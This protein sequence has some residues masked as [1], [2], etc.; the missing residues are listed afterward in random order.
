LP[1]S[2]LDSAQRLSAAGLDVM[3]LPLSR[4]RR[5]ADPRLHFQSM[6]GLVRDVRQ[7][8]RAI[9]HRSISLVQVCG[10][11]NIQGAIAARRGGIP[12][13]W[14]L[15]S[16]LVPYPIRVAMMPVVR[17]AADIVMTTGSGAAVLNAFPGLDRMGARWVPF[18]NPVD[19]ER[20]APDPARRARA[21]ERLGFPPDAIVIG[22]VGNRTLQKGHDVFV[23]AAVQARARDPRLRFCIVGAPVESNALYYEREVLAR[24]E[25][26]GL[27][28]RPDLVI[29]D[30]GR[31]VADLVT[32][33]D[34]FTLTSRTEGIPLA[35]LEAM[36]TCLPTV[37]PD[38][39]GMAETSPDG[40]TGFVLRSPGPA[41]YAG[42]WNDLAADPGLRQKLGQAGRALSIEKYSID[43]VADVHASAFMQAVTR[44][45]HPAS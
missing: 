10:L 31:D 4:F 6:T 7:L 20:F 19:T 25:A 27:F 33:F 39:G 35:L 1:E 28:E 32:A 23:E 11:H 37:I 24:A 29:V 12:V 13:V 9:H 21:R 17:R 3:P 40:N 26:H 14:Q 38:V 5:G 22:T 15:L 2:D 41:E 42:V 44:Q 30:G 45:G 43:A 36:A 16:A 34:I 8:G 18:F